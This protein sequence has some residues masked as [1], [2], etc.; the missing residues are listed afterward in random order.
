MF[1]TAASAA[2]TAPLADVSP[3]SVDK[4]STILVNDSI[5]SD[6]RFVLYQIATQVLPSK[7]LLW[8]SCG[9][10][11]PQL[12]KSSIKKM[13]RDA[14]SPNLFVRSITQELAESSLNG[15]PDG[16]SFLRLL[17][18][19]VAEW[20]SQA[21]STPSWLILDDLSTLAV[22][23]GPKLAYCLLASLQA[24]A[25]KSGSLGITFRCFNDVD[26]QPQIVRDWVGAGSEREASSE[27]IPWE[28]SL[29]ELADHVVDVCPLPSG[30][31]RDAHGRL[32]LTTIPSTS[33][34]F[35][36]CVTENEVLA[37][38]VRAK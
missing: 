21:S 28:R 4:A 34:V 29:I 3:W 9:P 30:P 2:S 31:S 25:T 6:G 22:L 14:S 16:V 12:I 27:C 20:A 26:Q 17:C 11:S 33:K 10:L 23:L 19:D 13:G 18:R 36:Y 35:N 8:L 15:R 38:R 24:L 5:E 7:R 32:V 37:I 1:K